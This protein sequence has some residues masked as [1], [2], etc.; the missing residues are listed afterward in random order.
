VI[1]LRQQN[2]FGD[3]V[4]IAF[5]AVQVLDGYLTYQGIRDFGLG[6]EIEGNPLVALAIGAFGVRIALILVKAFASLLGI[7]LHTRRYHRVLAAL[8]ALYVV[9]AI[10]PWVVLLYTNLIVR[11]RL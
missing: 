6:V 1:A 11:R 10:A 7:F 5:L 2:R 9:A 8:T 4:M 3:V